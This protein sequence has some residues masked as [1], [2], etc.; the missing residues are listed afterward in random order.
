MLGVLCGTGAAFCFAAGFVA[1]RHG[2]SAGLDPVDIALHRFVWAGI[3]MLP[4]ALRNGFAE[5]RA[6]GWGRALILTVVAG[7][8]QA[9][10]SYTGFTLVPLGH[11]VVIQPAS[12]TLAGMILA[13]LV[14]REPTTTRRMFGAAA[15][16]LGLGVFG[17]EAVATIGAH[18]VAGDLMFLIAGIAW[19]LFGVLLRQWRIAGTRAA[20]VICVLS[21]LL[22]APAHGLIHGYGRLVAVGL[23]ENLIQA[24][25]Q[26]LL[27]GL[28]GIYLFGRAV[29]LL[30]ASRASTFPA[31]VP[32]FG[33]AIG[34]LVLGEV[35]SSYQLLGLA[36]VAVGFRFA[37]K[38]AKGDQ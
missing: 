36:M 33:I 34:F 37:L 25:A 7:P 23:A 32:G 11:G 9:A 24:L 12:S 16:V 4:A 6:I 15:I 30:G 28:L 19:G 18:G 21:L 22:Y 20:I 5:L 29:T 17:G 8:L 26:G 27:A 38:R 1:A 31:L 3:A 10:L 13:I 2:I 35:P 14:L